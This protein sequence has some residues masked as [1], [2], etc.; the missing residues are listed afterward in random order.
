MVTYSMAWKNSG[1]MVQRGQLKRQQENKAQ[2]HLN[3][4]VGLLSCKGRAGCAKGFAGMGSEP[5]IL[6][7]GRAHVSRAVGRDNSAGF[8]AWTRGSPVK[9]L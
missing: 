7:I 5:L 2:C 3:T 9:S 1:K 4:I 6:C 8:S